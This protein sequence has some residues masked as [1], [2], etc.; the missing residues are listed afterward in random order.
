MSTI[1]T[2]TFSVFKMFVR[3]RQALFFTL[4]MPTI[5]M[6]IFGLVAFDRPPKVTIGVVSTSPTSSTQKFLNLLET[7]AVFD[8][9]T[10]SKSSEIA[11]L[12]RGD[13][14][15]VLLV[16]DSLIPEAGGAVSALGPPSETGTAASAR[17]LRRLRRDFR[18]GA[19]GAGRLSARAVAI[20]WI[21]PSSSRARSRVP[22]ARGV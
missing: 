3:N 15:V 10:G 19:F 11:A 21:G 6:L 2:L 5:I 16:P 7:I 18:A 12:E 9:E 20:S 22:F 1:W 17:F 13:R 14:T 8:V 4:F